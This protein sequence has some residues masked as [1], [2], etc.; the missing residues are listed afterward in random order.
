MIKIKDFRINK[1]NILGYVTLV[2]RKDFGLNVLI[3]SDKG[4][5]DKVTIICDDVE[6][7]DYYLTQLDDYFQPD[8]L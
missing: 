3:K 4:F 8:Y 5:L 6:E 7:R 1:E 2:D